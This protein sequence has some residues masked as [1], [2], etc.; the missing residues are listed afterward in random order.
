MYLR[1]VCVLCSFALLYFTLL[2]KVYNN[3]TTVLKTH[4]FSISSTLERIT[5]LP[6]YS[7][8]LKNKIY[9]NIDDCILYMCA[10]D[11]GD[12]GGACS[13]AVAFETIH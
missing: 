8:L 2:L 1:N 12:G 5:Y 13:A 6:F 7:L 11:C 10:F 9:C 3:S 4:T